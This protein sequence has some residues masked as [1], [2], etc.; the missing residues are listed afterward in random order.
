MMKKKLTEFKSIISAIF[1][2]LI[3]SNEEIV[4]TQKI[5]TTNLYNSKSSI[6]LPIR[7]EELDKGI[8]YGFIDTLGNEVITPQFQKTA[9]FYNGYCNVQIENKW[10]VIDYLGRWV[11]QANYTQIISSYQDDLVAV[12][13]GISN[14][15]NITESTIQYVDSTGKVIFDTG[16]PIMNAYNKKL[17]DY[18]HIYPYSEGVTIYGKPEKNNKQV[19]FLNKYGR[20]NS[21]KIYY[22]ALPFSEGL[23]PVA[24]NAQNLEKSW[25]YVDTKENII[26]EPKFYR[27]YPFKNEYAV[28]CIADKLNS[29][30]IAEQEKYGFI[31]KKGEIVTNPEFSNIFD[32]NG[33]HAIAYWKSGEK[34]KLGIINRKGE[35]LCET[36]HKYI[37]E[38]KSGY[39][40]IIT[41]DDKK[42]VIDSTGNFVFG[43]IPL[44]DSEIKLYE[45][46][47]FSICNSGRDQDPMVYFN[48]EGKKIWQKGIIPSK[49]QLITG[50]FICINPDKSIECLRIMKSEE[51]GHQAYYY[52]TKTQSP[53]KK[54]FK[55]NL[56]NVIPSK[57]SFMLQ[58]PGFPSFYP[59]IFDGAQTL[60]VNN[61]ENKLQKFIRVSF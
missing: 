25:G 34:F 47:I 16:R 44:V 51:T 48:K 37:S 55:I 36:D 1:F 28:V 38:I 57:R 58:F 8:L 45:N 21:D 23:A 50:N 18:E 29:H 13:S 15:Q 54:E 32:F 3:F 12:G 22:D 46:G 9:E 49:V 53:E 59:C 56:K 4:Y 10:G 43:P 61:P 42:G 20:F 24:I 14:E 17:E 39:A 52:S 7:Y 41:K 31:N 11:I 60:I 30:T 26:I 35:K 27:A 33:T 2:F 19:R 40:A 6:R 5:N